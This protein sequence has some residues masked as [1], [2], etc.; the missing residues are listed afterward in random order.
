MTTPGH[1][2]GANRAGRLIVL[3][4]P[5]GSGKTTLARTLVGMVPGLVRSVSYTTRAHR[6][7]ES[8]GV[9][10]H[11]VDRDTFCAMCE[12]DAFLEWAGIY[13][14]LYGT[15]MEA[16]GRVLDRGDDLLLV[17]D[18][19]GARWV[20]KRQP[21][22]L[23]IFLLPPGH[24]AL[25]D[26]LRGRGTESTGTE[27]ERLRTACEE[28]RAWTEYDYLIINDDLETAGQAAGAVIRAARQTRDRMAH[29]AEAIVRT[30]PPAGG[31]EV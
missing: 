14:E 1:T 15:G 29:R 6:A 5:S 9:D 16:T 21:D 13:G 17:I 31:I 12:N 4:A 18:V 24:P 2:E 28:I 30:F 25:E 20:R 8:D 27:T 19:Q 11:F 7:E 23:F 10:Y 3:S 26:R 22:A